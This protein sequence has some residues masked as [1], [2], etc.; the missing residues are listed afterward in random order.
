MKQMPKIPAHLPERLAIA[1]PI[2]GLFDTGSGAYHD[3]DRFVREHAERNFNC[4]RLEGGAGLTHDLNGNCRGAI[5]L[6][7]PFGAY[8]AARQIS[9]FGGEGTCDVMERLIALCTACKKYGVYLILSSWYFLHTYWYVDNSINR[10]LLSGAPQG[11]FLRFAKLLHYLLCELEQRGL[12][13]CIAAAEIFNEVTGAQIFM[14][15][16]TGA[17][18][19]GIDFQAA[20]EEA[21]AWLQERHPELLFFVDDD[22][23]SAQRVG[24]LPRNLQGFNGHNYFLWELYGGTLEAGTPVR[25]DFFCGERAAE[26]VA[27]G[28]GGLLPLS[29]GCAPWYTRVARCC[30]L[31]AD[32]LP[33]LEAYLTARLEERRAVYLERLDAFC[34]GFRRVMDAFPGV[35]VV[36]GEGVTYCSSQQLLWEEKS[37]AYWEM[38]KTAVLRYKELGVWGT[39]LKTCCGPEDPSWT[40]CKDRIKEINGLFL[41]KD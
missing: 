33:Q 18:V 37:D 23:V 27:Q 40:L 36:C 3:L 13:D 4:I 30:D 12:A 22:D 21:L 38:V 35:P 15:E 25:D 28:R 26:E 5:T 6:H 31:D 8:S 29:P 2:W 20:H 1:F 14:G 10:E 39:V 19:S 41:A 7:E 16:L 34:A 17:D 24:T 32:K 11:M 9:C